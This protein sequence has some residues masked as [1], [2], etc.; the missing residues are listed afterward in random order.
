[1]CSDPQSRMILDETLYVLAL[2]PQM[3]AGKKGSY[4]V[5]LFLLLLEFISVLRTALD[6]VQVLHK[7]DLF[8]FL[9]L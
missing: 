2:F 6:A 5:E 8:M 9:G 1:M 3:T 4:F 7:C